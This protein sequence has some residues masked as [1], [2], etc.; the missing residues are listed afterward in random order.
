MTKPSAGH[1]G[2]ILT[3]GE[4]N[5]E[6]PIDVRVVADYGLL[7]KGLLARVEALMRRDGPKEVQIAAAKWYCTFHPFPI[8]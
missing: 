2:A 1:A 5:Q 6:R 3:S 7:V 4:G 8:S